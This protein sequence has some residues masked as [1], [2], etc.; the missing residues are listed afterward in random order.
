MNKDE[1]N[2]NLLRFIESPTKF[3]CEVFFILNKEDGKS[4]KFADID[5]KDQEQLKIDLLS[6]INESIV[7]NDELR[8]VDISRI[9]ER[10]ETLF[11][12]DYD[13]LPQGF[14]PITILR[15]QHTFDTFSFTDDK[16]EEISG[17]VFI[18]SIEDLTFISYKQH[19]PINLYKRDSRAMGLWK[20]ENRLV[21]IPEDILKIYPDFDFFYLND[22]LFVKNI[23]VLE[24][25]F[26]Y[27]KVVS[28]KAKEGLEL[29]EASELVM[30]INFMEERISDMTFARKLAQIS[31]HSI[32]LNSLRIEHIV[33]FIDS[34]TPLADK[35]IFNQ[36]RSKFD[37]RTKKSQNLFLKL[38]NDDFLSSQ[39]TKLHYDSSSKDL[40]EV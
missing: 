12:Y 28:K 10:K 17:I 36:D 11:H 15:S 30:D 9:E 5:E 6:T 4:I 3:V 39:L 37:L 25:N 7:K 13:E 14:E 21:Q 34:F 32:V 20:S 19:Y 2:Q 38:L 33:E 26:G 29:I 31:N 27:N 1:L 16:F 23:K 40:V 22:D 24:R 18:I 35:F 8:I